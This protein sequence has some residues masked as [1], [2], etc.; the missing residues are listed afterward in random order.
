[1]APEW[2]SDRLRGGSQTATQVRAPRTLER[3]PVSSALSRFVERV[4]TA[5][6]AELAGAA[7]LGL[8]LAGGSAYVVGHNRSPAPP[9]PIIHSSK[10][11]ASAPSVFVHVAGLV[12]QPGVYE[13]KL[14]SRV[15][16]AIKAAGGAAA[17][18]DL[19]RLNLAA[20]L[21]DGQKVLVPKLGDPSSA[22]PSTA[23]ADQKVNLNEASQADLEKLPSVGPVLAQR[24]IDF[25]TKKGRFTST[26]QLLEVDGFGPKKFESLKD[27]IT[28]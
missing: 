18:A 19:D 22:G 10:R 11:P 12:S 13:L 28:V 17:G 9:P 6:G 24:I 3:G 27:L 21:T 7:L 15:I 4:R 1:M 14:G 23:G 2:A 8:V 20:K 25:R 26:R 16:D 5:S